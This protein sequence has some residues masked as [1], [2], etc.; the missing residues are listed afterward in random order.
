MT[1]PV[2]RALKRIHPDCE[3]HL[4][5]RSKFE[6]ATEGLKCVDRHLQLPTTSI[7]EP[8]IRPVL[9]IDVSVER[10]GRFID[11]LKAEEYDWVINF[12]FSPVSSYLTHA[13]SGPNTRVTGYTRHSDG[14]LSIPDEVSAYFYAQVGVNSFNRVHLTDI[15]VSMLGYEY[16]DADWDPPQVDGRD[17]GLPE[18]FILVHIGASEI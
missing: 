6:A 16:A 18:K 3:L 5:T 7:L 8:M 9:D 15:F 2:L 1:W 10:L 17:F 11:E 4:L 12:T 13:I 14:F